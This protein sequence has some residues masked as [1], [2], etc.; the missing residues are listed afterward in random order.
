MVDQQ[1]RVAKTLLEQHTPGFTVF[2]LRSYWQRTPQN[3]L[4]AGIENFGD[5]F[6][7]E[8]LDLRT[9]MMYQPGISFYAATNFAY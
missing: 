7:R 8:H 5:R 9:G 3:L 2:D 6:Y 4:V 1:N